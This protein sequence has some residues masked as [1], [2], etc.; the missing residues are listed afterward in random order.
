LWIALFDD[1][2]ALPMAERSLP[3]KAALV[4]SAHGLSFLLTAVLVVYLDFLLMVVLLFS[5]MST[6]SPR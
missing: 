2:F 4:V 1:L 5:W 6:L 3:L